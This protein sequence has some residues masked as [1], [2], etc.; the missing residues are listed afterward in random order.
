[1]DNQHELLTV[2]EVAAILR[3]DPTTIRR[4]AKQG[5][6]EVVELP[7]VNARR[8]YRIKRSTLN[9]VLGAGGQPEPV[10]SR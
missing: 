2:D 6:L 7:H 9:R 4:W 3:V 8:G 1:M 5:A 10:G